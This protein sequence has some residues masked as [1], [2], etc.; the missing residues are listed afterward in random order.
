MSTSTAEAP[1]DLLRRMFDDSIR[2]WDPV[3]QAWSTA[4]ST[5]PTVETAPATT[6]SGTRPST[7]RSERPSS[8]PRSVRA[9][10]IAAASGAR[11]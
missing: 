10:S 6:A 7:A 3:W 4:M 2:A 8:V 11:R 1:G 9:L 5:W